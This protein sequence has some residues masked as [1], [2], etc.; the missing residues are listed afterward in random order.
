MVVNESIEMLDTRI[1]PEKRR[2]EQMQQ[3]ADNNDDSFNRDADEKGNF[4]RP[5]HS[6]IGEAS[7]VSITCLAYACLVKPRGERVWERWEEGEE[8]EKGFVMKAA[9]AGR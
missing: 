5:S 7:M 8:I 3:I 4:L 2:E 1:Y 9:A 6:P